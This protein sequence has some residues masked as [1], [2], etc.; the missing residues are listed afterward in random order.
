MTSE[1]CVR[2]TTF[3]PSGGST[4][5]KMEGQYASIGRARLIL[6]QL[7]ETGNYAVSQKCLHSLDRGCPTRSPPDCIMRPVATFVNY[8]YKG[9]VIIIIIIIIITRHYNT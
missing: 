8:V 3:Q 4:Y 7:Q 5:S 1:Q 2:L 9:T 6:S